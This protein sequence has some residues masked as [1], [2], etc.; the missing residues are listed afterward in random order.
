[1]S[2]YFIQRFTI[3][4]K[5]FSHLHNTDE[6]YEF[7]KRFKGLKRVDNYIKNYRLWQAQLAAPGL[8]SEERETLLLEKEREKDELENY[9]K[10]ERVISHRDAHPESEYFVKW[11]GLNYEHCTWE[12]QGQVN[13]LAHDLVEAF[14][15]REKEA[16]FPYK[17]ALYSRNQRPKFVKI[18]DDP[19]YIIKTGGKLKDF[20]LTGLNWLAYLWCHGENGAYF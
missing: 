10:V 20:Q 2:S 9:C 3:K 14:R 7:L 4:W 13:A 1:M 18:T 16:K 5:G 11:Q 17:S 12:K 8:S 6:V 15:E 19:P